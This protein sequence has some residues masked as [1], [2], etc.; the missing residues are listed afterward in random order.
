MSVVT[1]VNNVVT[2]VNTVSVVTDVNSVM[3]AVNSVCGD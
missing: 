2:G 3:T 1:D